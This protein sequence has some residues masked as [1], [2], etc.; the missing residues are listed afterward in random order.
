VSII[1]A[2]KPASIAMP[3]LLEAVG[4]VEQQGDVNG[5]SLRVGASDRAEDLDTRRRQAKVPSTIIAPKP[6]TT[7]A[8][9][10]AAAASTAS[11]EDASH[12]SKYP[13]A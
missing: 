12:A 11:S 9:S 2:L 7:G 5:T 6:R 3:G 13:T 8:A 10:S 1:T 4:L